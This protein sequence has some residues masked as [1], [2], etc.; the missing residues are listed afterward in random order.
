[1]C[2]SDLNIM[3]KSIQPFMN[4]GYAFGLEMMN[5]GMNKAGGMGGM[6]G[7]GGGA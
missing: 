2:S 3:A 5:F 6:G 1:V 4:A 7:M